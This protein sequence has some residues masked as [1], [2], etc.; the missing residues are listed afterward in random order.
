MGQLLREYRKSVAISGMEISLR[1]ILFLSYVIIVS[2]F[3]FPYILHVIVIQTLILELFF[4]HY[5]NPKVIL[6]FSVEE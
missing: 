4:N 5:F 6:F 2:Y 3:S 1:I